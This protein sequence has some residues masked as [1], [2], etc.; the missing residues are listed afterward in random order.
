[1]SLSVSVYLTGLC[2]AAVSPMYDSSVLPCGFYPDL[3]LRGANVLSPT[4]FA[5]VD[6]SD[7]PSGPLI[8]VP[9]LVFIC[10]YPFQNSE[11]LHT[12]H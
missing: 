11:S 3:V 12:W 7:S 4:S 6:R 10:F 8:Y 1:M 2:L 9:Y 5:V